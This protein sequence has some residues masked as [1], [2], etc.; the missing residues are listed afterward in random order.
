MIQTLFGPPPDPGLLDRFK[1]AAAKTREGF[2]GQLD[3]LVQGKKEIDAELLDDLEM[4]LIGADIGVRTVAEIL[5]EVR[6][7]LDR[8]QLSDPAEL[9]TH[10]AQRLL[11]SH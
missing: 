6:E 2:V 11:G 1:T 8:N 7:S 3:D 4:L 5:D 9:K 10:I